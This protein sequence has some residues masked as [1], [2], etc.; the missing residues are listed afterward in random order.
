MKRNT[1]KSVMSKSKTTAELANRKGSRIVKANSCAR[2]EP[3]PSHHSEV[4]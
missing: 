3:V 4:Y 2:M 1:S